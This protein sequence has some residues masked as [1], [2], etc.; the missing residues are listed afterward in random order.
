MV[1]KFKG[2][3]WLGYAKEVSWFGGSEGF[4]R[5]QV[6]Y[7]G[8]RVN[9]LEPDHPDDSPNPQFTDPAYTIADI[10]AGVRG[11]DWQVS[12]FVN[13]LTDERAA[14]TT[15]SGLM[16]WGMANAAEGR[17]HVQRVYTNRPLE[18]GVRFTKSWGL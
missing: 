3:A 10:S 16:E 17:A 13:N 14:Y 2:S 8:E 9:I 7:T 15:G 6:S 11:E 18:A 5:F 4:M 12:I 1:P